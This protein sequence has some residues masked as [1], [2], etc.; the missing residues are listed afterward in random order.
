M[1]RTPGG[2]SP[3]IRGKCTCGWVHA[4]DLRII[5]ANTGKILH[6]NAVINHGE[7]HPREYGENWVGAPGDRRGAG[8]SPRIRGKWNITLTQKHESTDHPREYG[9][10]PGCDGRGDILMGSSPRIRGKYRAVVAATFQTRIIPANTGKINPL[11]LMRRHVADH[12]REYGENTIMR[13]TA[14]PVSGSSPRIRGKS[15]RRGG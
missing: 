11:P 13:S 15:T 14:R 6:K 1:I 2:S 3:R 12:P 8:S 7:D 5:P 10:N 9:E 4:R